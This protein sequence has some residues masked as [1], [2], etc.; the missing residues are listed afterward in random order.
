[1]N[2]L[3][4]I[5]YP[6]CH[7]DS[8]IVTGK[9]V[10]LLHYADLPCNQ[11]LNDDTLIKN[12]NENKKR[13]LRTPLI[14]AQK[15]Y[16]ENLIKHGINVRRLNH[17]PYPYANDKLF[18]LYDHD[19]T[20]KLSGLFK[21]SHSGYAKI[22]HRLVL[23][24]RNVE[25]K[26]A[27]E[28]TNIT[29]SNE[30]NYNEQSIINLHLKF[31]G[32]KWYKPFLFWFTLK[33]D[34]RDLVKNSSKTKRGDQSTII[35][36]E[37]R[38]YFIQM[39]RNLVTIIEKKNF[40]TH[41]FTNEMI[42]MFC[43][44]VEGRLM[45]DVAMN[46]DFR[47][48]DF[49][50]RGDA[51]W[52]LFDGLFQD[53]GN[54]T[55]NII[56]MIEP[57]TLG[58]LQLNDKSP[59][60]RGAFLKYALDEMREEFKSNGY[61]DDN[62]INYIED[63][64][65]KIFDVPDLHMIAEFFSFFRTF[66]HPTLEATEAAKKVREHM[67]KPKLIKFKTM[68][69]G[70]AL[71]CS[72]IINGFRER[73]GGSWPPLTLP[74]HA[75]KSIKNAYHNNEAITDEL[76][77]REWK[78]FVGL[79][80]KCFMPLTLDEDLTMFMKDKALAAIKSEWDSVY[81][82][83]AM[84]YH[85]PS[86][87][88]SRRLVETFLNDSEFDPVNLM[89]YVINGEYLTDPDFNL[90][91]SLKE[92]E[93]K[94]VGRL[95]AKMTYKMRAC[96]VVAESLIAN[97]VGKYFKENGM[98]K[99]EHELLKTLHRLSSSAVP[100]DNKMYDKAEI[101][102]ATIYKDNIDKNAKKVTVKNYVKTQK[103]INFTAPE[104]DSIDPYIKQ[105]DIR[106]VQYE[107]MSTF[108]TT[109]LQKFCLN[110]RQES[111]NLFA[112]RL[113]EIYGLPGFFNWMHKRLEKSILYVAD[114]YCPPYNTENME[115]DDVENK[116]IF[117]KYPMGGIEGY[118]QKMWTIITI[119]FLFL[120]AYEV[121]TKIAAVVQG[122]NQAIAI[123]RR[124]HPNL[125]FRQKKI[126][127]TELAQKYFNRL[128]INMGAIG[129][130]LK[131]NETIISSHFFVY[132]KRIYYD[133]L[134]L[135]Q[136][137]KPISRVVFWSETIV[138]ET[139]SACS[140][141][142]TAIAKS[143]EQGFSR[144]IG[145]ALNLLKVFQ[146]LIISLK[147]TI[148]P[149]MTDDI[150][151]PLI[152]NQ[153]WLTSAA[154]I[155]AQLG[156]FNYLNMCRLYVR[157]VG[158]PVTASI[159]DVK[160]LIKAKLLSENIIQ[161]IMHQESG[162]CDFL[163]WASDPYSLNIQSSQS[164]TVMLKNITART[165]LTNSDNPMLK[166]LFHFDFDQ[167]DRDLAR[168]LLDRPIIMPRAAHEIMDNSLTGARQEIAGMLDTTKGLIRNSIRM[169]AIR[170]RLVDKLSLYDYNQFRSFNN[171]MKVKETDDLITSDACS[172]H[173]ALTLRKK[174]WARLAQGRPIYGLEVPDTIEVVRG[175]ILDD[176][177]D[178][179][180]C[181]KG[182]KEYGWFFV[183][184]NCEL[185][186]V[187]KES[188]QMRV[189]YF[190]STTDERSEIKLS[191]TRSPSRALKAAIRIAMVYTW[192]F[193]DTDECWNEAWY[194]A[195]FRANLSIDELKAITPIST[196]NNIA[197]RLRDKSTQMKYS[198]SS[199]NRVGRYIVIS[200]DNLNF[201]KD[202]AKIDTN[203]VFQQ[204]MLLGISVLEDRFRYLE[205][206]GDS[207]TLLHFHINTSCCILEMNDHP[208]ITTD[209]VLPQLQL[210]DSNKLIYDSEP[211][212]DDEV[213]R[214]H[215]QLYRSNL[216]DFPN[217][218][219]DMLYLTL[220]QSL[221]LTIVDIITKENRDHLNEFKVLAL[222]DDI[223]SLIT[224]FLLIEPNQFALYLGLYVAVNWAFDIYYRR[225]EGKYQ[226]IEFL[227]T[228]M[229]T[230]PRNNFNVLANAISHPVVFEKFWNEGLIE[231]A[232]GPNI[233]NQ[234]FNK[235]AIDLI[236]KSYSMYIDFW[237]DDGEIDYMLTE[238]EDDI[239][240]QRFEITQARHLCFLASLYLGRSE[241]PIIRGM[242][243][244][245]KC[246]VLSDKLNDQRMIYGRYID[247]NLDILT[248]TI[249]PASLTYIRRGTVKHLKLRKYISAESIGYDKLLSINAQP[250]L[251]E[252]HVPKEIKIDTESY[253]F[254]AN[255]IF[256]HDFDQYNYPVDH[257]KNKN[258]WEC[259][260]Q[261][262]VGINSTSCYKAVELST[263]LSDKVAKGGNR[264]FLGEGSGSM[265]ATYYFTL[266]R[267][268]NYF[269]TG[270]SSSDTLGQRVL[271]L[272]PS[273]Y[274]I[275]AKNSPDD[276]NMMNDLTILFNGKP[277]ST[278]IGSINSFRYI[279]NTVPHNFANFVHSDMESSH[280]KDNYTILK[281]QIHA[282]CLA[283]NIGNNDVV[284]V[285]KIAPR[286]DDYTRNLI[287]IM[288]Q[289]FENITLFIPSQS[290]P[291]SSEAY[292]VLWSKKTTTLVYPDL[293]MD[294]ALKSDLWSGIDVA[295]II[296]NFKIR[297]YL[298]NL[299]AQKNIDDYLT[300]GLK[301]L[302]R[303]EKHLMSFGFKL[304]GPKC[305]KRICGHDISTGQ[306]NLLSNINI[307]LNHIINHMD[308][309]RDIIPFF[310][311]Y[312]I[313]EDT[314][315]KE[316]FSTLT[317][318]I[319]LYLIVYGSDRFR[320]ERRKAID[321]IRRRTLYLDLNDPD[322]RELFR[323]YL[324]KRLA[325][326]SIKHHWAF[327]IETSEIK[328]WWKAIGYSLLLLDNPPS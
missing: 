233:M 242:T 78:S 174:M 318:K 294:I 25:S 26:L 192:A 300:S 184:K 281:E 24:K 163:D 227:N 117:I 177:E 314:K 16:R 160:R 273:E 307:Q 261:R 95:F 254:P 265:M 178:C 84:V 19:L 31:E 208:Y 260:I 244:I 41:Y 111:S 100:K 137:L 1:M 29:R 14:N 120:S 145:Y 264:L 66:G 49:K 232:Y 220:A 319:Y 52:T 5:I 309:N 91:Y 259:H 115:L 4:D 70:H 129:H 176:C 215:N 203:L 105:T 298:P 109:D 90:S 308:T 247:W 125:S 35:F 185:D 94:R 71:F 73:H 53:L 328:V 60:L 36:Y 248:V 112:E 288:Y 316:L 93:I 148:N 47:Y 58:F 155:P 274:A 135:S 303:I 50:Q 305:I 280:E 271:S 159:A 6:E 8:P 97:G 206:T 55:Y 180:Y 56:A 253:F 222:D 326:L 39:N 182:S 295:S 207:N 322:I 186:S 255:S 204:I 172:V 133:G 46:S 236:I 65:Y 219:I 89:N 277:E 241:M 263:Y 297:N 258:R 229:L 325:N 88:T 249:Y 197:H 239:V 77:I 252:V 123:T 143:I 251:F 321:N 169:G 110:W 151:N 40:E 200:N 189:P 122:D 74:D 284:F 81:P 187:N 92:K 18:R 279:M 190:G 17:I 312:P 126:L 313:L 209:N 51:L 301:S 132:S 231:P 320:H 166:G 23:L 3:N 282:L 272:S 327:K 214:I 175:Y 44:V 124:V 20:K 310:N 230:T 216:L 11:T 304:N 150:V 315:L 183:P 171:L 270:V 79:K 161:K 101:N 181:I 83:E 107:T 167:E 57:L 158:D 157:N 131:A 193:G 257:F 286:T 275:V 10:E 68:M 156:G 21:L 289:H 80:F 238:V 202:G 223:N 113:N 9:L 234:D 302:T 217:W 69:K 246:T 317:I 292:L 196:S 291:Y 170:P 106:N 245:E 38:N 85:A 121:G 226:M 210:V 149:S 33:T 306:E 191:H 63:I 82:K 15:E 162:N 287:N 142:S 198:G 147:F 13:G 7:L 67:N 2:N 194:L 103:S 48:R 61:N 76:A 87:S 62:E 324:V 290:N 139:R 201:E 218:T 136:A 75:S 240:N 144:W 114:P 299:I 45:I 237:L 37:L 269:N 235:I 104:I 43:D 276:F 173:L 267:A 98:A 250:K 311:P 32:S 27:V 119:P 268:M 134:A 195:S 22:S 130:N 102:S 243:S 116:Q 205:N 128:R 54:Q 138:D 28:K 266:G 188:N 96:Q 225:P 141:I 278:W 168:Y 99:D 199:L 108:L 262:R 213:N 179:D 59:V 72:F 296:L 140:N 154:L 211:L 118:C 127:S 164:V 30:E 153:S 212:I 256:S 228:I 86:Q 221:A 12:I 42:L 146:Q 224:E 323:P 34:F 293:I 64:L 152:K 285:T 165:I 283:I